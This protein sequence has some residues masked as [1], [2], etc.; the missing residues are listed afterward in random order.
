LFTDRIE[1]RDPR[2]SDRETDRIAK[3]ERAGVAIA[4]DPGIK[5]PAADIRE[6]RPDEDVLLPWFLDPLHGRG[7]Q[8]HLWNLFGKDAPIVRHGD[9]A[10]ITA[11]DL[12]RTASGWEVSPQDMITLLERITRYYR[13]AE[14]YITENGS[15]YEDFVNEDGTIADL[16]RRRY[17]VRHLAAFHDVLAKGIRYADI[18]PGA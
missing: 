16:E 13:P 15:S 10:V 18:S 9:P 12:D 5:L 14:L 2:G 7:Y 8:T 17:L 11:A 4:H 3:I 6:H 1:V